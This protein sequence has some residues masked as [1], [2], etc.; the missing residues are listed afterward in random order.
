MRLSLTPKEQWQ[1]ADFWWAA[2]TQTPQAG[3]LHLSNTLPKAF[4]HSTKCWAQILVLK[5]ECDESSLS[6]SDTSRTLTAAARME[7]DSL[8]Q[9]STKPYRSS[10]I[11][12]LC[13]EAKLWTSKAENFFLSGGTK[14]LAKQDV[15]WC[16]QTKRERVQPSGHA[17]YLNVGFLFEW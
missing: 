1:N 11:V 3:R 17:C 16:W 13:L 10:R 15:Y 9:T 14:K 6:S 7:P 5:H 4:R 2:R 8:Y 12:H